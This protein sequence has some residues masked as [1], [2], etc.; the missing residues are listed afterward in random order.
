MQ[1]LKFGGTSVANGE[2]INKVV[3]LVKKSLEK[4]RT[5]LVVSALGGI[6]DMLIA[7]GNLAAAGEESYKEKL[8]EIEQRHLETIKTLLPIT[9]LSATLSAIKTR[10]NE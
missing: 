8:Q 6:T 10:C 3:T 2:N 1:V 7:A 9:R 4:D 5:L